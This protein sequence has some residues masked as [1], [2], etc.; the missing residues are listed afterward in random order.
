MP[1]LTIENIPDDLYGQLTIRANL[2]NRSIES[3]VLACLEQALLPKKIQPRER[4]SHIEQ[5]RAAITPNQ[6]TAEDIDLEI[7]KG[8]P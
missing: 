4:L 7:N 3:E 1:D 6:I 5:L 2:N 8:R